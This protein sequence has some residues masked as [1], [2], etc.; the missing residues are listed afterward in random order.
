MRQRE[1]SCAGG[2]GSP[3]EKTQCP[4]HFSGVRGCAWKLKR[5]EEYNSGEAAQKAKTIC[6]PSPDSLDRGGMVS[7]T[8]KWAVAVGGSWG[9]SGSLGSVS[10]Q[11]GSISWGAVGV[12]AGSLGG[13]RMSWGL[14]D[15]ALSEDKSTRQVCP[16]PRPPPKA[17]AFGGDPPD[18]QHWPLSPCLPCEVHCGLG[19]A[20]P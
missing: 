16:T 12:V 18:R 7:R 19:W 2:M 20:H 13:S 9:Q 11:P 6:R 15:Q 17:W 1:R 8:T 5:C 10:G 4:Y 14:G 3:R